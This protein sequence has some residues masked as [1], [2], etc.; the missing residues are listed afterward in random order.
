MTDLF[1][2]IHQEAIL[3][4]THNDI[5]TQAIERGH[6]FDDN[7][8]GK[9]HSDL[10]RWKKG[11]V[12]VQ[13]F[14]VWSDGDQKEP[15]NYALQQ[16]NIFDAVLKR[17]PNKVVLARNST[18]LHT[19]LNE[20]KLA[21][22]LALEGGH[23]IESDLSKLD[24]FYKRGVRYMTLTWNNSNSW[25]TSAS[26][27]THKK[28]LKNKGLTNFGKEVIQRMNQLGML[29]DISH[30]GEAT[31]W[32]VLKASTKPVF[33]SHSNAFALC[34]HERNLKDDQIKAIAEMDGVIQVNFFSGF[35]DP[36]YY[37]NKSA[38][39]KRHKNEYDALISEGKHIYIAEEYLFNKYREEVEVFRASFESV[40]AHIQYIINLVGID[41]V[42]IGSDFDGIE[43]PAL[44]LDDVTTYPLITKALVEK[45]Y[46]KENITKIL[47]GNFL[48]V[49]KANE[50]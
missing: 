5:L 37:E 45:G 22:M 41:Y 46:S 39:I 3:I 48:R 38:F 2:E 47:G 27:E 33:A 8:E 14:V 30:I 12:D 50:D 11:G 20:N 6:I 4:D 28:D 35:L 31:F 15:Y 44:Q 24:A 34:P 23:M 1:Q 7:L 25:A 18:E 49:L 43:S 40:I 17:S 9:T 36:N 26:D 19:A 32:D 42:G 10:L 13:F 21:A 29:V 16:L